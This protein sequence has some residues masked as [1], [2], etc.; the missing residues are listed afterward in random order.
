MTEPKKPNDP[1]AMEKLKASR[2]RYAG[3]LTRA[4]DQYKDRAQVASVALLDV[5]RDRITSQLKKL[6][7]CHDSF[8]ELLTDDEEITNAEDWMESYFD[9]ASEALID[10]EKLT[11]RK[12]D[13]SI[14]SPTSAD[15]KMSA[16]STESSKTTSQMQVSS[17]CDDEHTDVSPTVEGGS[18][19]AQ[20]KAID[21]W[22]DDLVIGSESVVT[23]TPHS[24]DLQ[25]VLTRLELER[26][27]PKVDLPCFDGA[28]ITWPRFIE[29]FH[30]QVHSRP[31]LADSRR[32]DLL[33][34]HVKG[35]A[36]KLI[37][38]LGYSGRNYAQSLKELKFAFGH[39]VHVARAYI[40]SLTSGG[41]LQSCDANALR[42]FYV[43]VRDCVTTL[44]QMNY[45]SELFSCDILQRVSRRIP[46][47]K[48]TRW[49]EFVRRISS[50]REPNLID[51]QDWLKNCVEAEFNPYAITSRPQ[52]VQPTSTSPTP[53][54]HTTLNTASISSDKSH[55]KKC[56]VC[57]QIHHISR[58][59]DYVGISPEDR[60]ALAKSKR[61]CFNCLYAG[62]HLSDCKSSVV[63]KVNGCEKRHH[64]SLHRNRTESTQAHVS[65]LQKKKSSVYFQVLPVIVQGTN[66]RCI[67]TFAI[68]DSA[69][70]VT[71]INEE[72]AK[73]LGL[74]GPKKTLVLNTLSSPVP[75]ESTCVK[76]SVREPN[77]PDA[78]LIWIQ[79]AWTR[80][81]SFSCPPM[82]TSDVHEF[83]HLRDLH[84]LDVDRQEIKLLIGANVP[85]AHLQ[86]E[87]KEGQ[88]DEPVA[89]QTQLGWCVM[90]PMPQK[91]R[92]QQDAFVN[93]ITADEKLNQQVERFW[94]TESFGITSKFKKP[95]SIEDL[96]AQER[97]E[98]DTRFVDGHYEVPMLWKN[99]D[100]CMP[101][102]KGL[103]EKRFKSLCKR[104][105]FNETLKDKYISVVN[106]YI[107]K[108]H[109]RKLSLK[110]VEVLTDKTW[111][112][113]HHCVLNAKKP[114]K[115]RVVFDAAASL[116]GISLNNQLLVGPDLLNS[117]FGVVQRFRMKPVAVVADVT[118]MYHQVRVPEVDS[119][120]LRF[121]WTQDLND[122]TPDVYKM[123][124]HIFGA[125]DSPCCANYALR[126]VASEIADS[127]PQASNAIIRNFYVDDMLLSADDESSALKIASSVDTALAARG[128]TL[129]KWM[130][131][132]KEV[133]SRFPRKMR[134]SPDL[135]LGL[136]A[137]PME[138]ALGLNWNV[139]TDSFSFCPVLK[140]VPT[141]K[142]G[143]VS[144]ASSIFDPCGFLAPF[145]FRVKCI[146][147]E[148]WRAKVGWDDPVPDIL[149][150]R[151]NQWQ[152]ELRH[153]G[154]LNIPRYHGFSCEG[155]AVEI[156]FF[157]DASQDG[158]AS[159]AYIRAV[160]ASNVVRCSFIAAKSH[161]APVK[162]ALT[163][164][165]LELQG[166]VMS[167]RLF[168]TLKNELDLDIISATF[169]TDS[170]TVLR[171][172]YNESKRWKVFV[173]NRVS[174]IRESSE[175]EQ[176]RHVPSSLNSADFATRGMSAHDHTLENMWFRGPEYLWLPKS[177][178]PVMPEVG[179][180][181]TDEN[182]RQANLFNTKE[183]DSCSIINLFNIDGLI[184][185]NRFSDWSVLRKRVGWILRAIRNFLSKC[186]R[187]K[188]SSI[189]QSELQ[190]EELQ[191]AE[192]AL[193]RL[194]QRE[195]YDKEF[196]TLS[197]GSS[198]DGKSSLLSLDPFFDP[199]I[200][201]IR[202][203]GRLR[204]SPKHLEVTHQ[205]LLPHDHR[206][207]QLIVRAAH[208]E[209]AHAGPEQV[210]AH[211]RRNYWP[212]KCRVTAKKMIRDCFYCRK[213]TA[214]PSP[215]FMADLPS[216]R[217]SGYAR[218]FLYVGVDYFGPMQ[219]KRARSR[220]KRWGCIFT[221]LVTRAIHLELVESL[222]TD[223]FIMTLR[224]FIARRGKPNEIFSDNGTNFRGANREL[225][226]CLD[227]INQ[228][229]VTRYLHSAF[230]KWKFI[231]PSAPHF[232]GAWERLV[233]SVKTTLKAVLQ[234]QCVSEP[235]LRTAL[236]EVEAVIN[237]RPLTYNSSDPND[238]TALTPNHFLQGS[239]SDAVPPGSF[240]KE[241][242]CSRKRWRQ[243]Q[244]IADHL[245][246]R[247][248]LEYLPTLTLRS[249]W[250]TDVPNLRVNDL[251]LL[252]EDQLPRGQWPL[253]RVEDVFP[254]IDGRVRTVKVKTSRGSYTRPAHKVCIL[255]ESV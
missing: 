37:Q 152:D 141:T 32:M 108:G 171:Y 137:L 51:L 147:Q 117:V 72:L 34:S 23:S 6:Q 86:I 44:H 138:R 38:G 213:R 114:D 25:E 249:K 165:K 187:L 247:W 190:C 81:G 47:D 89:I 139:Q 140:D 75:V 183:E 201:L 109:A 157:S 74:K 100:V 106:S 143:M 10:L 207:T 5:Q 204:N 226:Q 105:S 150:T 240:T 131:S 193:V 227:S 185:V 67:D 43:A 217:L 57:A 104:L 85:K 243:A 113:P 7:T 30:V 146:I 129:T 251:V 192:L 248:R 70:D 49:N 135:D 200:N 184:D 28:P 58:C 1:S 223:D 134:A 215:P 209:L 24:T 252:A 63:C 20:T 156:H 159:V 237:S 170:L 111:Y 151:W 244:V 79:E 186:S 56:P 82:H 53:S 142:R 96:K 14:E 172:I 199:S 231:P 18:L 221:C 250:T 155:D 197:S 116:K 169:W 61:L 62:H 163:I 214:K 121:L 118:D 126:R 65:N 168:N 180:P 97:L 45:T 228:E 83:D 136:N 233:R 195:R 48:R 73:D 99:Q 91:S 254:S 178:W 27:L 179:N 229:E 238:Y 90:G 241:D 220:V 198:M 206:V 177:S 92:S 46:S 224:C 29:Q 31:G 225:Q 203:G 133:L 12:K 19:P 60:Y 219:V 160:D 234:N 119:D 222:E 110:E 17:N 130:S 95:T 216:Q 84:L 39:R 176:W 33:Q 245:W 148:I 173:A 64:T 22:I 253:G 149:Q 205:L 78:R 103:A 68:L 125:T 175:P 236:L 255:E 16:V 162:Q 166:A 191:D 194:A 144:A 107:T 202:V 87:V 124:V 80:R 52:R 132:S 8:L 102:S 158:F 167:I 128:F 174:E 77:N 145:T 112:L 188:L 218:A 13:P 235:V 239:P 71:I 66:G 11:Q 40:N 59:S 189:S 26:D 196:S 208:I 123:V 127:D 3:W 55:L 164:P 88:S 230:I 181:A 93:F 120:S 50:S 35:E 122:K 242:G 98:T 76:F 246:N 161:V 101:D 154:N 115:V 232:G 42:N 212:V 2:S 94:Q 211:V 36:R 210:I 4:I 54:R 41:I 153:L 21:A 15:P 69:S 9:K 182:L